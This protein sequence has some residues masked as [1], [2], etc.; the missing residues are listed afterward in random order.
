MSETGGFPNKGTHQLDEVCSGHSISHVFLAEHQQV[1]HFP[2]LSTDRNQSGP[3]NYGDH[4]Q[5]TRSFWLIN[6]KK[7]MGE[8]TQRDKDTLW[9]A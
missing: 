1:R 2:A 4:T 8:E 6:R 7:G 9:L 5:G 3:S